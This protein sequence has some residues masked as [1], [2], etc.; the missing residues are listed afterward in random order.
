MGRVADRV[1]DVDGFV[2]DVVVS[3]QDQERAGFAEFRHI[4]LEI[5][6]PF[7]FESL[8][9]ITRSAGGMVDAYHAQ[10]AEIGPDE[11]AFVV[12]SG[13][14][15]SLF[16]MVG[17]LFAK[18]GHAAISFF[19]GREAVCG[20]SGTGDFHGGNLFG[21]GF[22]LLQADDIRSAILQPVDETFVHRRTDSVHIVG[23]DFFLVH[24]PGFFHEEATRFCVLCRSRPRIAAI[25]PL[26]KVG[27]LLEIR[28][29]TPG[30]GLFL[31]NLQ[32]GGGYPSSGLGPVWNPVFVKCA[33]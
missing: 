21:L 17:F 3:G 12:V 10:V 4:V 9:F 25:P 28:G 29:G 24:V 2:A 18:E 7:H 5:G 32:D 30:N 31:L 26:A 14:P 13:N 33:K 1:V 27:N 23:D 6:Q 16:D 8:A 20:V 22:G 15:H 11:P 19:L